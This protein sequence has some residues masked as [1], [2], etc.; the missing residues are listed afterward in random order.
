MSRNHI[1][2][3]AQNVLSLDLY[4]VMFCCIENSPYIEF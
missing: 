2:I 4:F 1:F 3:I